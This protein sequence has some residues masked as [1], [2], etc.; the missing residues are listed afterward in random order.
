MPNPLPVTDGS[1][2]PQSSKSSSI[3]KNQEFIKSKG[4]FIGR[5]HLGE[6][7]LCSSPPSSSGV[8]NYRKKADWGDTQKSSGNHSCLFSSFS[9]QLFP[10]RRRCREINRITTQER[11]M[12][13][14]EC[15]VW[16]QSLHCTGRWQKSFLMRVFIACKLSHCWSAPHRLGMFSSSQLSATKEYIF[17][18]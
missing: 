10:A 17:S 7:T 18:G 4:F 12:P 5:V 11:T 6:Y 13:I 2:A 14:D 9:I 8:R 1:G 15:I 3:F 16:Q